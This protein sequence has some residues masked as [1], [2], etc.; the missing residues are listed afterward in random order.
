MGLQDHTILAGIGALGWSA[1]D[2]AKFL[3]GSHPATRAVM[4]F[5]VVTPRL[6]TDLEHPL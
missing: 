4:A 1:G 5:Y 3:T 6:F 2:T